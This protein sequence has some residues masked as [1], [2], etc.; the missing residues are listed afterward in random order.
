MNEAKQFLKLPYSGRQ[1]LEDYENHQ[2][3]NKLFKLINSNIKTQKT[4]S[5]KSVRRATFRG[6]LRKYLN[7]DDSEMVKIEASKKDKQLYFNTINE[8][9][10]RQRINTVD[11]ELIKKIIVSDKINLLLMTSGLR[12]QELTE[13]ESKYVNNIIY[14]KINKKINSKF[15]KI[16]PIIEPSK[17]WKIYQV[18]KSELIGKISSSTVGEINKKLNEV[19]PENFY[20]RSSHIN[21]AIY[22][23]FYTKFLNSD[24][25]TPPQLIKK[26]LHHSGSNSSAHYQYINLADDVKK[27]VFNRF[28]I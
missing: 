18:I 11:K 27:N 28:D 12:I 19:I 17:W 3:K 10:A 9:L 15:Y 6:L 21:R 22:V 5:S 2:N 23:K 24:N 25:L 4:I 26:I 20:K 8:G 14:F 16:Y 13:N 7:F 1:I